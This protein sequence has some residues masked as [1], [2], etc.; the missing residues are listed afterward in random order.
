MF[1]RRQTF[2]ANISGKHFGQTF[3]ANTGKHGQ[4]FILFHVV[5]FCLQNE[6]FFN[7]LHQDCF[8]LLIKQ[9]LFQYS[10]PI[11]LHFVSFC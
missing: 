6:G 1:S 8:I 9:M 5:S 10:V 3:R 4:T 7:I 2:R 11:L